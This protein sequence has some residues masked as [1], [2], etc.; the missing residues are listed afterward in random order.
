MKE[1]QSGNCKMDDRESNSV[2]DSIVP[3]VYSMCMNVP[4]SAVGGCLR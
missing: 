2:T 4:R 1:L 3:V